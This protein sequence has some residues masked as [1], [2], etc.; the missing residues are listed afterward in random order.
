MKKYVLALILWIAL[1]SGATAQRKILLKL[2]DLGSRNGHSTAEPVL[3]LLLQRKIKAGLG[4]IATWLDSTAKQAY[5]KYIY[6]A[7]EKGRKQFEIW[8]HGF[9]HSNKNQPD[10]NSPEFKGTGY[11]FQKEHLAKAHERVRQLL[12]VSMHT[13]GAPFNQSDTVTNKV[14]AEHNAYF[15]VL[16]SEDRSGLKGWMDNYNYRVDMEITTGQ[17]NFDHFVADYER[18]KNKYQGMMVLQGHPNMWDAARIAEFNKILDYLVAQKCTFILP[19]QN[20]LTKR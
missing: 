10:G 9:D 5:D 4:V 8:N 13:F 18:K 17:V 6:A 7:D 3:D 11:A 15:V 19:E 20:Y 14:L 1:A 16:Y 12:G 2:D